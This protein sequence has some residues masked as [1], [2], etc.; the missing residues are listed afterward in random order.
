MKWRVVVTVIVVLSGVIFS[1]AIFHP[2][3]EPVNKSLEISWA[4]TE[5]GTHSVLNAFTYPIYDNEP[6]T[7]ND[8]LNKNIIVNIF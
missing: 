4:A 3:Q 5:S 1:R 8:L 6:E 7:D 2:G